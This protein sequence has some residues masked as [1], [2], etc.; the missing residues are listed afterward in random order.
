MSEFGQNE[1]SLR[2]LWA[3]E[4]NLP[5]QF[6]LIDENGFIS[7]SDVVNQ[8][9]TIEEAARLLGPG[10]SEDDVIAL[11]IQ[12]VGQISD[13][14]FPDLQ[15]FRKNPTWS[16]QD[17]DYEFTAWKSRFERQAREDRRKGLQIQK[18]ID[19]MREIKPL[20]MSPVMFS[21]I[22]IEC[23]PMN[24]EGSAFGLYDGQ[25]I[26]DRAVLSPDVPFICYRDDKDIRYKIY[27]NVS[28]DNLIPSPDKLT[29]KHYVYYQVRSKE[30]SYVLLS[31]NLVDN[32][33]SGQ[34]PLR[35]ENEETIL[36]RW[37]STDD[38]IRR[39]PTKEIR[40]SSSFNLW[41]VSFED[42]SLL[43]TIMN[44]DLFSLYFTLLEE[45][46]VISTERRKL[47]F[48]YRVLGGDRKTRNVSYHNA[49]R[50]RD[51][52]DD[53]EI[54]MEREII[55]KGAIRRQLQKE[56]N[57]RAVTFSPDFSEG[58]YPYITVNITNARNRKMTMEVVEILRRL[59]DYYFFDQEENTLSIF[60]TFLG[61]PVAQEI[62]IEEE[63]E[64][65][66]IN[67]LVRYA[68]DI[69]S[70]NCGRKCQKKD[71]PSIILTEE[72]LQK[73]REEGLDLM[74]YPLVLPDEF[75]EQ[76]NPIV[77]GDGVPN[78]DTYWFTCRT[79]EKPFIG[80]QRKKGQRDHGKYPHI[81]HCFKT[82]QKDPIQ[83]TED[84]REWFG[85]ENI[86]SKR[87]SE[88]TLVSNKILQTGQEGTL[89]PKV[90]D[91]LRGLVG[92]DEFIR[93][94]VR[95]SR[96]AF[97]SAVLTCLGKLNKERE[98][99][100]R[101]LTLPKEVFRTELYDYSNDEIS[102]L[103]NSE[104][105]MDSKLLLTGIEE[106]LSV[107]IVVF[108]LPRNTNDTKVTVEI[109]R[110]KGFPIRTYR[111]DRPVV[112][113]FKHWGSERDRREYPHYEPI[114]QRQNKKE[115][116]QW[117]GD[118]VA[119]VYQV[120]RRMTSLL[121]IKKEDAYRDLYQIVDCRALFSGYQI[122]GQSFDSWGKVRSFSLLVNDEVVSIFVPP[123]RA[124]AVPEKEPTPSTVSN[125]TSIFTSLPTSISEE[126]GRTVGIW[127]K[128]LDNDLFIPVL[129]TDS[130]S[131]LP[132]K[133]IPISVGSSRLE[134]VISLEKSLAIITQSVKWVF[135]L[136]QNKR[137][138]TPEE[139]FEK[140][141][142]VDDVS[143]STKFYDFTS[144]PARLPLVSSAQ[145]ALQ[146]LAS[147]TKN[148]I[149]E[150]RFIMYNEDF[151]QKMYDF[152]RRFNQSF[153]GLPMKIPQ[154]ILGVYQYASDFSKQRHVTIIVGNQNLEEWIH[155][156]NTT[157]SISFQITQT[158]DSFPEFLITSFEGQTR[159]FI[160]Q[161]VLDNSLKRC[162]SLAY[163]WQR[164]R[165]NKVPEYDLQ[166][167]APTLI[168]QER[169]NVLEVKFA[170]NVDMEGEP[171][172]IL[173]IGSRYYTLLP[174]I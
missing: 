115:Q 46:Q 16:L 21:R 51:I 148:F 104:T 14:I 38:M 139:F 172:L 126:N 95:T 93:Y 23:S 24:L 149:E 103:L 57:G 151:A 54:S 164:Y 7:A 125:A 70:G 76:G 34:I 162:K 153:F 157:L 20:D 75:D 45:T 146:Y 165:Q 36:T 66:E 156:M 83:A 88:I 52:L 173:Q 55:T 60:E 31:W 39:D 1:I 170:D 28:L 85:L 40:I 127:Y 121:T 82:N 11:W 160:V 73:A 61:Y 6:V 129:P 30:D 42:A 119:K 150:D 106:L 132:R 94:S 48:R 137:E 134:R 114:F 59:M 32:V 122:V 133:Q 87:V 145:Q 18:V 97:L 143:D 27:D 71:Q 15:A 147:K 110:Y 44:D 4:H 117:S 86:S 123:S 120:L 67:K 49:R 29:V 90:S 116:S 26:F 99:F 77:R 168:V 78:D 47:T 155:Q 174:L 98:S 22:T 171:L 158:D 112:F 63:R 92:G 64:E 100:E 13:D 53:A 33:L 50:T 74:Q 84:N 169:N 105:W 154:E 62:E 163:H 159:A 80:V 167:I 111:P 65:R 144:L 72:E 141:I 12:K 96:F 138:M 130:F 102:E 69:F 131:D 89:P 43:D 108:Y 2:Y 25:T 56:E 3:A 118:V 152:I 166:I 161:K 17:L 8:A 128:M 107:N 58:D 35:I 19:K 79:E 142:D 81:V 113:I 9:E 109:P 101:L 124:L 10:F 37:N 5:I 41:Q 135:L 140:Y 136:L 91:F 68:P